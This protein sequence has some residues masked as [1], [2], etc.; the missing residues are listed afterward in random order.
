[1]LPDMVNITEA[2][3]HD[4]YGQQQLVFVKRTIMVEGQR[5]YFDFELMYEQDQNRK[6]V[7]PY[8]NQYGL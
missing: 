6:R 8:K 1:M 5:V 4:L 2:K 7:C 3:V